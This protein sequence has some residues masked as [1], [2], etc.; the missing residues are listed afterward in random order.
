MKMNTLRAHGIGNLTADP[1][2]R[3]AKGKDLCVLRVAFDDGTH[4]DG[5]DREPS[6]FTVNVWGTFAKPCAQHLAKGRQVFIDGRL[7]QNRW[8]DSDERW[9][10]RAEINADTVKFLGGGQRTDDDA[11]PNSDPNAPAMTPAGGAPDDTDIPF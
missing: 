11:A 6:Y 5:S 8:Q 2:L 9:C 3:D 7:R 1:E 10:E 4:S